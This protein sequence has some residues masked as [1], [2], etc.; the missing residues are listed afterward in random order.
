M[1]I[2]S[3][4]K[5]LSCGGVE[6]ATHR[7]IETKPFPRYPALAN[8]TWDRCFEMNG[9]EILEFFVRPLCGNIDVT[10]L[11]YMLS[12]MMQQPAYSLAPW[13]EVITF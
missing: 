7:Q 3:M 6:S 4:I 2:M 11:A 10:R 12:F 5:R 13:S 9:D 1:N 8:L